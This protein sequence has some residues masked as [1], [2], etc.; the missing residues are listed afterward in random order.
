MAP[1]P[2]KRPWTRR[3]VDAVKRGLSPV[4]NVGHPTIQ[5]HLARLDVRDPQFIGWVQGSGYEL[6]ELW[7]RCP[8]ADWLLELALGARLRK[9]MII[10]AVEL[11]LDAMAAEGLPDFAALD[12]R[13]RAA[14]RSWGAGEAHAEELLTRFSDALILVLDNSRR[15]RSARRRAVMKTTVPQMF[16]GRIQDIGPNEDLDFL[17]GLADKVRDNVPFE[18]LREAVLHQ[19]R[20]RE[21]APYR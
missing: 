9:E 4:F 10:E 17:H 14:L 21:G 11:C 3:L 16:S 6:E 20:E 18:E 1:R 7:T 12:A 13:A 8:R 19:G 2:T 5:D 15:L